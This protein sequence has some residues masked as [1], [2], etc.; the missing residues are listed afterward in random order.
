MVI[1]PKAR[2]R[3]IVLFTLMLALFS[4]IGSKIALAIVDNDKA[5]EIVTMRYQYNGTDALDVTDQN[6]W[7]D[8]SNTNPSP[9][10][11]EAELPCIVEF[12]S[13]EYTDI[14]AFL[15][16]HPSLEDIMRAEELIST[17]SEG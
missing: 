2:L 1:L 4:F 17:K 12:E 14:Q 7:T 5:E 16:D 9:C 6:A 15:N 3:A 8:V 10:D 13:S 11:E